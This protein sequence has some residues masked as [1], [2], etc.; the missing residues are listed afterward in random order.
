MASAAEPMNLGA[1]SGIA[2]RA[3]QA[4]GRVDKELRTGASGVSASPPD[5]PTARMRRAMEGAYNGGGNA[6]AFARYVSGDGVSITRLT[7]GG[8][9]VCYVSAQVN[10]SPAAAMS[11]RGGGGGAREVNCPPVDAGWSRQ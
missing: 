9:A 2:E 10:M 11:G 8:R 7:R 6:T 1:D 4:A 5:T 3:L